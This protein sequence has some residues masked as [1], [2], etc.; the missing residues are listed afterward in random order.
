MRMLTRR[1]QALRAR[2]RRCAPECLCGP[3]CDDDLAAHLTALGV[4]PARY[5]GA[6]RELREGARAVGSV[7]GLASSARPAPRAASA[8]AVRAVRSMLAHREVPAGVAAAAAAALARGLTRT[9]AAAMARDLRAFPKR[10][11]APEADPW[12]DWSPPP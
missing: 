6:D 7:A 4:D 8:E 3:C 11:A 12:A 9:E 10:P 5:A 2:K 1:Q